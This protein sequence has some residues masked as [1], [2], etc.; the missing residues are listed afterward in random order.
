[1]NRIVRLVTATSLAVVVVLTAGCAAHR[2]QVLARE[3]LDRADYEAALV[4]LEAALREHPGHAELRSDW[5]RVRSDVVTRLIAAAGAARAQGQFAEADAALQR[6]ARL[7][8]ENAR[9]RDLLAALI[10]ERRQVDALAQAGRRLRAE[11]L[12][13]HC[14]SRKTH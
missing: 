12:Q 11:S 8:P 14:V 7:E 6:A 10:I 2:A 9:V 4:T 3:Q 13:P 5:L 1:M